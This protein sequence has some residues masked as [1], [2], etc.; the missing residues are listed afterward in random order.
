VHFGVC[1]NLL[2]VYC[3]LD[4]QYGQESADWCFGQRGTSCTTD[5]FH[6]V[7][8]FKV[9]YK[10]GLEWLF[11]RGQR[12]SMPCNYALS[13]WLRPLLPAKTGPQRLFS[14]GLFQH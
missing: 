9:T 5:S 3:A 2:I 10:N 1:T 4:L 14:T 8:P 13:L 11:L 6:D 12:A 7:I